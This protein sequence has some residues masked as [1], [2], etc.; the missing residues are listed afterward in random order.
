MSSVADGGTEAVALGA[1]RDPE[2][3]SRSWCSSVAPWSVQI[4]TLTGGPVVQD[5]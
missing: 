5:R 3:W 2:N 1:G 4:S